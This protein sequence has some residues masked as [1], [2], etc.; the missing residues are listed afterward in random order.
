MISNISSPT[1]QLVEGKGTQRGLL[2]RMNPINLFHGEARSPQLISPSG[3]S[4]GEPDNQ[5][6]TN[7][8]AAGKRYAYK[9]PAKPVPG[10]R[11]A[12]ERS[13]AQGVQAQQAHRTGESVLAY[14]KATQLDP[15]YYDAQYNLGLAA[16]EAGNF[17]VALNA[18]EYAL[19]NRPDSLDA[20]YN[21]A[22]VLKQAN[23]LAD[24]ANEFEKALIQYPHE[25]R[26]HLALGN[27]YAQQLRDPVKARQQ[28]LKFLEIEPQH[29]QAGAIRYWL[30]ANPR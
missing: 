27:L 13:F 10:D 28:Y 15:S 1:A 24:A 20:R 26:A 8:E 4:Q 14:R 11:A 29:P 25:A 19:A 2:Q 3:S 16:T 6:T 12:A 9:S 21:F 17:Q 22:L 7:P 23:Y 5:P 18:Y 30:A